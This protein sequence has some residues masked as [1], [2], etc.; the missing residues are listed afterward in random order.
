MTYNIIVINHGLVS[1]LLLTNPWDA[2]NKG[3]SMSLWLA[4][5]I[6]LK[7]EL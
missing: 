6:E 2:S 4:M 5:M 1:I 7:S 3:I